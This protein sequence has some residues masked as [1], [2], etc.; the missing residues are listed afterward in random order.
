L[1]I[2]DSD[3]ILIN[4]TIANN[5]ADDDGGGIYLTATNADEDTL[6]LKNSILWGNTAGDSRN[7][8]FRTS[9]RS[10]FTYCIYKDSS[11]DISSSS[12]ATGSSNNLTTNPQFINATAMD[13]R[14][15]GT[16]P[17]V[18]AGNDSDNPLL[19]DI[20]RNPFGRKI[21]KTDAG[22]SGPIDR[23]AY[24]YNENTEDSDGDGLNDVIENAQCTGTLACDSDGDGIQ[25]I[26]D[27]DSDNDGLPDAVEDTGCNGTIPCTPSDSDGDGIPDY[28][29]QDTDNDGIA[30][31]DEDSDCTGTLPCAPTDTDE[32]G[33][34]DYKDPDSDGDG[35]P[36]VV[37]DSFC[38]IDM[39]PLLLRDASMAT[40]TCDTDGDGTPDYRDLDSD[41]DGIPDS[42][43]DTACTGVPG[44]TPTDSDNDGTPD[45]LD[46]DSDDD[47]IPDEVENSYCALFP[48][49]STAAIEN[50]SGTTSTC[51]SDGDG[52]PNY[53]D[54]DSD[55]DGISDDNEDTGCSGL[56]PCT[57]TD[58]DDDGLPD[59]LEGCVNPED[60]G[61]IGAD[62]YLCPGMLA[63]TI[64][65]I[66]E[67]S[68]HTGDLEYKWQVSSTGGGI[69]FDDIPN[70]N[71]VTYGP[72]IL[73]QSRWYRRLAKV[74][75]KE[76]WSTTGISNE[77][78]VIVQPVSSQFL[79]V[80]TV[81]Q[82]KCDPPTGCSVT[83]SGLPVLSWRMEQQGPVDGYIEGVGNP[84]II[85]NLP[86]GVYKFRVAGP[87]GCF[88]TPPFGVIIVTY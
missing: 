71:S 28:I 64:V 42:I 75:C 87:E 77:V 67:P 61:S 21:L 57:P 54:T 50:V 26:I 63:E 52:T 32:D 29:D 85:E 1:Y 3:P 31:S 66:A 83:I 74:T 15:K 58:S 35:I 39:K 88:Q 24:E 19:S 18:D 46:V 41:G 45:F 80:Q 7:Q 17:G 9:A 5:R 44:C 43:E 40:S 23:G 56:V 48:P 69:G 30:D 27:L 8:M 22:L 6:V 68:G 36:D 11:N 10:I 78:T 72:G 38:D 16:S 20:R 14:L 12:L 25:D 55:N 76:E 73:Q 65:S 4:A 33:I 37:E 62:Q 34:P 70:S 79:S 60:A 84:V 81:R 51:D 82:P 59:F 2:D 49:M 53:I 86:D 13:F 47:G